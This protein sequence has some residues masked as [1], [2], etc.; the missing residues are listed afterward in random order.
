VGLDGCCGDTRIEEVL[1]RAR[2]GLG[3]A[4]GEARVRCG[5]RVVSEGE[6]LG[7]MASAEGA[8][9]LVMCAERERGGMPVGCFGSGG[10]QARELREARALLEEEVRRHGEAVAQWTK[11]R[12]ALEE[13]KAGLA[14]QLRMM[15]DKAPPAAAPV[16]RGLEAEAGVDS[17]PR[18]AQTMAAA[19]GVPAG[20]EPRVRQTAQLR[21]ESHIHSCVCAYARARALACARVR[22][23][24]GGGMRGMMGGI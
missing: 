7:T 4:D 19:V 6:T 3:L 2:A 1:E 8:V 16:Q 13:E 10:Q 5:A 22:V 11:D 18:A 24:L 23:W 21:D 17:A 20:Q 15:S 9:D 12:R 14:A